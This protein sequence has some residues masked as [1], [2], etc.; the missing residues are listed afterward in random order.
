[1]MSSGRTVSVRWNRVLACAYLLIMLAA[2]A[3]ASEP[4]A[5]SSTLGASSSTEEESPPTEG[6]RWFFNMGSTAGFAIDQ[7][8]DL[9]RFVVELD[10]GALATV[11][12]TE[13]FVVRVGPE[14]GLQAGSD[15]FFA[16]WPGV[17]ATVYSYP[18][19]R[20]PPH[21]AYGVGLDVQVG[22]GLV[23]EQACLAGISFGATCISGRTNSADSIR[24]RLGLAWTLSH[25][26]EV[27]YPG[28]EFLGGTAADRAQFSFFA[29]FGARFGL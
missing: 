22:Y 5:D 11:V 9:R 29:G 14:V 4:A 25:Y 20:S 15:D 23:W 19:G 21:D 7:G 16:A 24:A 12:G 6:S 18:W 27:I 3:E 10:V 17:R 2:P 26:F 28:L 13:R 8:F 1:M